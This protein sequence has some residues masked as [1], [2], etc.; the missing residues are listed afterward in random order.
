M[1]VARQV[2][3]AM[4]LFVLPFLYFAS[5]VLVVTGIFVM[6]YAMEYGG[7]LHPHVEPLY[8]Y[9]EMTSRIDEIVLAVILVIGGLVFGLCGRLLLLMEGRRPPTFVDHLRR[10]AY[11]YVFFVI[12][13]AVL[14]PNYVEGV[15][16]GYPGVETQEEVVWLVAAYGIVVD[17]LMLAWRRWRLERLEPGDVT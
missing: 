6:F 12:L 3:Q 2:Q 9:D 4:R 7:P 13:S 1:S 5:M 11:L 8:R 15:R 10:C 16:A 14:I 17:A